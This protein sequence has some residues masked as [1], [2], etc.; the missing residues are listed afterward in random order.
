MQQSLAASTC[1]AENAIE[2]DSMPISPDEELQLQSPSTIR[3]LLA[4][5]HQLVRAGICALLESLDDIEVVA[6][7]SDGLS[8]L[9]WIENAEREN[10]LPD[11]AILDISLGG[12][13]G[14][15]ACARIAQDFPEVRTMILSMHSSEEYVLRALRN[16]AG[17]YLLKDSGF[18]ELEIAVRTVAQGERYFS[19]PVLR[20]IV[21]DYVRRIG[22]EEDPNALLTPRQREILTLIAEG[23]TTGQIATQLS[24]STKTV[25]THRA[26]LMARLEIFDI[27]GLVRYALRT[28][29]ID[30]R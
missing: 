3:I 14:L 9:Q 15:E 8:A 30:S 6:Q 10:T 25:E 21:D 28:G 2:H 29:L 12:M 18:N 4:E 7:V 20:H 5:D 26:Q 19:P 23:K 13:S 16:G 1:Q 24:I 11:V 27:P 22:A 17:A